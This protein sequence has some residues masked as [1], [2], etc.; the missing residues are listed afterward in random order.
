MLTKEMV[1]LELVKKVERAEKE[2]KKTRTWCEKCADLEAAVGKSLVRDRWQIGFSLDVKKEDLPAI[3]KVVG[4]LKMTGKRLGSTTP[5]QE[6]VIVG[7]R[8]M[9]KDWDCLEFEYPVK[10]RAGKCKIVEQP[11]YSYKT[12]VC[13]A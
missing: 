3:R 2:L 6:T 12:L 7:L 4:R 9:S 1:A 13:S 10:Y 8:P 11:G 5:G